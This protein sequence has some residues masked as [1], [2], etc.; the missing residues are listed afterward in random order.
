MKYCKACKVKVN[1]ENAVCPLCYV[2]LQNDAKKGV[3]DIFPKRTVNEIESKKNTLLLRIF[4]MLSIITVSVSL[5]VNLATDSNN[6]WSLLIIFSTIYL[7][8][9][10]L[11]TILSKRNLFEKIFLQLILIFTILFTSE[12]LYGQGLWMFDFVM[13]SIF[14]LTIFVL[15]FISLFWGKKHRFLLSCLV[16]YF[17][18]LAYSIVVLSISLLNHL[19]LTQLLLIYVS[20]SIFGTFL[21]AWKTIKSDIVKQM[22]L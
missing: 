12:R 1:T 5:F 4:V 9:I 18:V 13:P 21:F 22:H 20:I 11:H 7:W 15:N 3:L 6:L 8:V 14:L 2:E 17:L 19:L 16:M 10:I